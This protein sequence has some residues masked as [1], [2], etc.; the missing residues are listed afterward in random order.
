[1][2]SYEKKVSIPIISDFSIFLKSDEISMN[3]KFAEIGKN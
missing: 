2:R 3:Q 1:M